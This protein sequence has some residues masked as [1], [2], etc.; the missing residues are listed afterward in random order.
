M[1]GRQPG[2]CAVFDRPAGDRFPHPD[3]AGFECP[4]CFPGASVRGLPH[5]HYGS[6]PRAATG[7]PTFLKSALPPFAFTKGLFSR[8]KRNPKRIFHYHGGKK[9]RKSKLSF[10]FVSQRHPER[11]QGPRQA[12]S[13]KPPSAS[14]LVALN[15]AASIFALSRLI[16]CVVSKMRPKVIT[17]FALHPFGS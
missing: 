2:A 16:L 17:P 14:G 12:P 15:L 10:G 8:T 5:P 11:G 9:R 6:T 4:Q 1:L 3:P 7:I 13:R